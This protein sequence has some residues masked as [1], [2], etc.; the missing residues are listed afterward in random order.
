MAN[1]I[2]PIPD[3]EASYKRLAKK[4]P[5]LAGEVEALEAELLANPSI[6]EPLGAGL[7]KVRLA[8]ADKGTG[9]SGGFRVITY[10]VRESKNSTDIWL[11]AIYDKSEESS[12]TKKNLV[13]IV[14]GYFG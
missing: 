8:S 7:Y 11:V 14:K 9:K 4:F 10:L 3:F 2:S 5:A 6:G 13:K 1:K 12:M